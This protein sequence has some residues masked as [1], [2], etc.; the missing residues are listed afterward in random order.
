[1]V[2]Y[3]KLSRKMAVLQIDEAIMFVHAITSI[4]MPIA[5]TDT[6]II[7]FPSTQSLVI[8]LIHLIF[9]WCCI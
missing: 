6:I 8:W 5:I 4:C 1:M 2:T 3:P 7:R 9:A